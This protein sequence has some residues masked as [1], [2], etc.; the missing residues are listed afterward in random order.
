VPYV[1]GFAGLLLFSEVL[2][3]IGLHCM[4][5][6]DGHAIENLYVIGMD[7]LLAKDSAFYHDNFAGSLTKRALS[8]AT[9]FEDFADTLMF[10][11]VG[12]LVPIGFACVI[13]WRYSPWLV[14]ALLGLLAVTAVAVTPLI[15][16]RQHLVDQRE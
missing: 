6:L 16:R 5:R 3:R 12:N 9:R 11:V 8:F 13:L 1:L 15:R 10:N 2:W 14:A 7:E 4:N